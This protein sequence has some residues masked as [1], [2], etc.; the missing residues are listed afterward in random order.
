MDRDLGLIRSEHGRKRPRPPR[1]G[2]SGGSLE[3]PDQ[4]ALPDHGA[5]I[6]R[7]NSTPNPALTFVANY[8]H[9]LQRTDIPSP[10]TAIN[11]KILI[12][13]LPNTDTISQSLNF[14]FI[15]AFSPPYV[16]FIPLGGVASELFFPGGS[17]DSR[18]RAL[19]DLRNGLA[20]FIRDYQPDMNQRFQWPLNIET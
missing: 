12:S 13:Y 2:H 19:I 15:F 10:R 14:Y 17:A 16:P 9:C 18:N 11:T 20:A 5:W 6:S 4:H 8:P 1:R 3:N 7:L